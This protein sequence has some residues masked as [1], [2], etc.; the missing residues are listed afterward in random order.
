MNNVESI[1]SWIS[2]ALARYC[3]TLCTQE[4]FTKVLKKIVAYVK[5]R[6]DKTETILDDWVVE[7]VTDIV[8]ND[9]KMTCLYKHII[10]AIRS[11]GGIVACSGSEEPFYEAI[12][13]SLAEIDA[14]NNTPKTY[15]VSLQLIVQ[16]LQVI[17]PLLTDWF[18]EKETSDD[19]E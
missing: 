6:A 19:A 15:S 17:V 10:T 9:E 13:E 5:L 12:A 2:E 3:T 14:R 7:F 8:N 4:N 16:L 11:N 1:K 18:S